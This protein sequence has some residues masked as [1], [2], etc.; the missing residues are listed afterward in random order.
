MKKIVIFVFFVF[1]I[2]LNVLA[3]DIIV[4]RNGDIINGIVTEVSTSHIK[5]K[6]ISNPDGPLYTLEKNEV[7]S[8]KYEN[9]DVD[10]F[11]TSTP[12]TKVEQSQSVCIK[13][14]PASDNEEQKEAY[15]KLPKLN[16]KTSNKI[17][18]EFFPIMAFTESSVISTNEVTIFVEPEG[19]EYYDGGWKVKI[20][21]TFMI[22]N[23]T[24]NPIYIDRANCFKRDSDLDSKSYFDNTQTTVTHGNNINGGIGIGVGA[25]GVGIGSGSSSSHSETYGVDRFLVIGPKSKAKLVEYKYIRLSENKAEFK[26]VSDI[27]Y[28]SFDFLSKSNL[29]QGEVKTY[30]EQDSPYSNSYQIKYSTDQEFKKSYILD[31]G[32]YAKYI[33]GAKMKAARWSMLAGAAKIVEEYNKFIPEFW[34]SSLT[35]IGTPGEY[36]K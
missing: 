25:L 29:K 6:K 21:Y 18:K 30:T 33:V 34:H 23:K 16:L 2:S 27:E 1:L 10:K 31:F 8:I 36:L 20:G 28:W 22:L 17:S 32:L 14:V 11:D 5:Y 12:N 35:I 7:L 26:T 19:A 24:D 15:A 4:L 3:H 13:A 9:G